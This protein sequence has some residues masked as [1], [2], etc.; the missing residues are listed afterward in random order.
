MSDIAGWAATGHLTLVTSIGA[1]TCGCLPVVGIVEVSARDMMC[2]FRGSGPSEEECRILR[3]R[4]PGEG[5][6]QYIT[7][8]AAG[9]RVTPNDL[10]LMAED[11]HKFE[12]ERDLLRR[13]ALPTGSAPRY[14]WE[15]MTI[16]LI[17]RFN[18]HGLPATQAELINEIQDWFV[19]HSP[20]GEIPEE[21]TTRKKIAPI[22]RALR[23]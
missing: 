10:L 6:W 18:D 4:Q 8:P 14:D 15:G 16:M 21:S 1:V 20:D 11:V 9:L 23:G 2:M 19:Q 5:H 17:K 3:I 7:D 13:P 22:W 12:D